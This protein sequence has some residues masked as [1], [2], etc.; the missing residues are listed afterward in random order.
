[1]N[2][3][4]SSFLFPL[5][6]LPLSVPGLLGDECQR[7]SVAAAQEMA[8]IENLPRHAMNLFDWAPERRLAAGVNGGWSV[9][10]VI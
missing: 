2:S 5:P 6:S 3:S 1:M 8:R 7:C 9:G 10:G 4:F